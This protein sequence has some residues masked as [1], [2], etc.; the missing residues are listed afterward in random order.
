MKITTIAAAAV[1][2]AVSIAAQAERIQGAPATVVSIDSKAST[3]T[4]KVKFQDEP[5]E[6]ERTIAWDAATEFTVETALGQP[7]APSN[8]S[9]IKPGSKIY[10]RMT[11]RNSGGKTFWFKGVKLMK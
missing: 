4:V 7:G 6:T 8:V 10:A 11:D 9:A 1:L 3:M 5:A 2:F